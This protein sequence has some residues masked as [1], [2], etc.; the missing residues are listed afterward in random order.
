MATLEQISQQ[1]RDAGM[2]A[3][4]KLPGGMGDELTPTEVDKEQLA[5]GIAVEMEHTND[6]AIAKEIALDHLAEDPQ[7]YDKL[8]TMESEGVDKKL[9]SRFAA[10]RLRYLTPK[11]FIKVGLD[12]YKYAVHV[13]GVGTWY[14]NSESEAKR[15]AEKQKQA[16]N[17]PMILD[18]GNINQASI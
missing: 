7:Y 15:E 6:E 2:A 3:E 5:K 17:F 16:G 14:F 11:D 8:E 18:K 12:K 9:F 10:K 1:I 4:Q 13:K